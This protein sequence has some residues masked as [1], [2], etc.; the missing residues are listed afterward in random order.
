MNNDVRHC[1][2]LGGQI[3]NHLKGLSLY[4]IF[5]MLLSVIKTY[6]LDA[7]DLA[8]TSSWCF[9]FLVFFLYLKTFYI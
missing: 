2:Y 6:I 4:S 5:Q 3:Q 9:V 1:K 8:Q 7:P